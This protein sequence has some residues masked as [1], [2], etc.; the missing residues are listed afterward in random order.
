MNEYLFIV[1]P[2]LEDEAPVQINRSALQR[3]K[4]EGWKIETKAEKDK[5]LGKA[6][7]AVKK[8]AAKKLAELDE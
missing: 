2:D 4:K 3:Y 1:H 8:K 5:R 7:K 6:E